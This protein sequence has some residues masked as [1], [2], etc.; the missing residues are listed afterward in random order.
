MVAASVDNAKRE[1]IR[2]VE[3]PYTADTNKPER[4]VHVDSIISACHRCLYERLAYLT[5]VKQHVVA[6]LAGAEQLSL[7]GDLKTVCHRNCVEHLEGSRG[8]RVGSA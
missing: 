1:S 6:E 5:E 2:R 8:A 3:R 4:D 7:F